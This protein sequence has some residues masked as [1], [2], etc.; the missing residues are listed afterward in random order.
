MDT[1]V[2]NL[3]ILCYKVKVIDYSLFSPSEF[4]INDKIM[5]K[6]FQ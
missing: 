6:Y 4:E 3:L 1:S 5:L 2:L